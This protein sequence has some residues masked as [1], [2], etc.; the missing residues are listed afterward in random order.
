MLAPAASATG[1]R[2]TA[3]ARPSVVHTAA[4][5]GTSVGAGVGA[6]AAANPAVGAAR[7]TPGMGSRPSAV[8]YLDRPGMGPGIERN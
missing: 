4:A 7:R 5:V 2:R 6:T 1:N 3:C 8:G